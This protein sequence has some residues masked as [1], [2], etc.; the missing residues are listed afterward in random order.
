MQIVGD[1]AAVVHDG[2]GV[3]FVCVGI[4]VVVERDGDQGGVTGERLVDGVVEYFP[5]E[6]VETVGSGGSNVYTR[7]VERK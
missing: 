1:A 6:V 2:D 3:A 7:V 4:V 5:D